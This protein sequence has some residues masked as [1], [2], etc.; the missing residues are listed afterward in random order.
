MAKVLTVP[1]VEKLK[2]DRARRLEVPDGGLPGLYF[3]IQPSGKKSWAVRYRAAGAP[4][5]L[6]LSPAYPAL[7]LAEARKKAARALIEVS[8][9]GDPAKDKRLSKGASA[10]AAGPAE[11]LVKDVVERFLQRHVARNSLRSA[12]EI[13]RM[14]RKN[15]LPA[16]GERRIQDISRADVRE[17]LN[18]M[19]D[20]GIGSM[21]NRVFSII[22]KLF[23]WA[24]EEDIVVASPCVKMRPPVPETSRDR[25]LSDQEIRWFWQ[26]A[27]SLN[28]PFGPLTHLLLLTGQRLSEVAEMTWVEVDETKRLWIIPRERVKNNTAHEVPLGAAAMDLIAALPRLANKQRFVFTTTA[29]TAASGFSRAKINLDSAM[30]A[31]ARQEA[32]DRDDDPNEVSIPRWTFHDLRRT[33]ASGMARIGINLPVIEKVLNHT[34]GSFRGIVGVYQRHSFSDEK[35][36]ALEGWGRFLFTLLEQRPADNV[37][38][39]QAVK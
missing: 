9:G 38:P 28:Y 20:A 14:F 30:L 39:R 17:L 34:S 15:V 35:R 16:W 6:T 13:E 31:L 18:G 29:S 3:V 32:V 27:K 21:T 12:G 5:K 25:V 10:P 8:E 22:R 7:D 36:A 37:I 33:A 24:I 23:N 4:R 2:P 26:A 19:M 11:I 1:M